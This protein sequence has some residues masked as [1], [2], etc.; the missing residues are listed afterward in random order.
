MHYENNE[1][2]DHYEHYAH[3]ENYE[4]FE[5]YFDYLIQVH[6]KPILPSFTIVHTAF[7]SHSVD[8]HI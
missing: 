6:I 8:K 7:W 4:H 5:K 2:C 3:Y 1:N